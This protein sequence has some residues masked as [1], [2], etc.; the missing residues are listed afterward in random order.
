MRTFYVC[1]VVSSIYLFLFSS[2][3]LSRRRLDVC[4]TSTHGAALVRIQ[5]A[6]L[7]RAARGSLQIQ[8]AKN[9]QKFAIWAPSQL[10]HVS[11][12]GKKLI[13]QQYLLHTFA[14]C[15]ELRPTSGWDLLASLGHP[16]KFQRLSRLDSV[17]VA[18]SLNGSQPNL[19]RCLAV[20]WVSTLHIHF[21]GFLPVTE[22]LPGAKF[23]LR[24][25]LALSYFG[26]V[27]V[28]HSSSGRQP[29]FAALS[30]GRHLHSVGRPSRWALA[31]ILV[32]LL[33]PFFKN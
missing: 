30:T 26:S 33:V 16:C 8:D 7:R 25:S 17:T 31:H 1:P 9:R 22:F 29:N 6:S 13:K 27:T 4:H 24:A 28:R 14:Q 11:T 3:N 15:G 20:T 18:T 19:A 21:W 12:I 2:P 5:D 32:L 23:T 10:R